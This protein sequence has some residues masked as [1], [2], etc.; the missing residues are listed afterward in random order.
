MSLH[1]ATAGIVLPVEPLTR[2]AFFP[3]GER[4]EAPELAHQRNHYTAWLGS[5]RASMTPRLHVNRVACLDLP[6]IVTTLERHPW[7]A[8]IF[9]PLDVARYLVVVAPAGSSSEPD[10]SAARAFVAPGNVGVVYR[11][12][13]WHAGASVLDRPGSFGVLMWRNDTADDEEFLTLS[14]PLE[15]CP[16]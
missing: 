9:L 5:G 11:A 14:Q 4:I 2:D 6:H 13:T 3:F 1:P 12:G 7:S 16:A 10:L 15:I 8:Q